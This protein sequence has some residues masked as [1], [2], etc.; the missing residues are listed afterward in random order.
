MAAGKT[1]HVITYGD[2]VPAGLA[3]FAEDHQPAPA[4]SGV[5]V[6]WSLGNSR[7]FAVGD[8]VLWVERDGRERQEHWNTCWP[9]VCDLKVPVGDADRNWV[10]YWRYADADAKPWGEVV[11]SVAFHARG[12]ELRLD[13]YVRR[14]DVVD[15]VFRLFP[16]V[17]LPPSPEATLADFLAEVGS[18]DLAALADRLADDTHLDV[19]VYDEGSGVS[20]SY[21]AHDGAQGKTFDYDVTAE[22]FWARAA[23]V[24][25]ETLRLQA[26]CD[27]GR[28]I[29]EVEGFPISLVGPEGGTYDFTPWPYDR[30][31]RGSWT[32]REWEAKRFVTVYGDEVVPVVL[33]EGGGAIRANTRLS[34]LRRMAADG[35]L[36][37]PEFFAE[38]WL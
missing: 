11:K 19:G 21:G 3:R 1:L 9:A 7:A 28:E 34:T 22:E 13:S 31:A 26:Y 15:A 29:E 12:Y 27:L 2:R 16:G 6:D 37:G 32:L 4:G 10:Y 24:E 14:A 5:F 35:E 25:R 8:V 17:L 36:Q 20:V 33:R 18:V 38:S 30:A 23:E